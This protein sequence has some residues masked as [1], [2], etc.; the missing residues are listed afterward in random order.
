MTSQI[1]F[2]TTGE[3]QKVGESLGDILRENCILLVGDPRVNLET[4]LGDSYPR[5]VDM[6]PKVYIEMASIWR[7]KH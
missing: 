7:Q 6:V 3:I 4:L 1:I 5:I 2:F